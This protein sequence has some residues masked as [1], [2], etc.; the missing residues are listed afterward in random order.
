MADKIS[1]IVT[2]SNAESHLRRCVDSILAQTYGHFELILVGGSTAVCG[3]YAQKDS[4]IRVLRTENGSVSDARNAGLDAAAGDYISFIGSDDWVHPQYFE[5]LLSVLKKHGAP[6]S[7]CGFERV[8]TYF[9]GGPVAADKAAVVMLDA[10]GLSGLQ[11][12]RSR[13]WGKLFAADALRGI[14]FCTGEED[15]LAQI[16]KTH[17]NARVAFSPLAVFYEFF[18]TA[19]R[20]VV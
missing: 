1:I 18:G 12:I 2:V 20:E 14:R 4:R 6:I 8:R 5:V 17:P 7:A 13:V 3:E 10:K 9:M 15:F 16:L 11:H 19:H